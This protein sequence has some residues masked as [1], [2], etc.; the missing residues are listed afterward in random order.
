[1]GLNSDKRLKKLMKKEW[2]KITNQ[3]SGNPEILVYGVLSP[4]PDED[5]V[6]Y[7]DFQAAFRQLE[8][9][10]S[11]CTIRFN[12]LGG[13]I[14]EGFPIYDMI[15]N[16]AMRSLGIVEGCA[17]SMASVL[18]LACDEIQINQ[19]AYF[20]VHRA[21]GGVYGDVDSIRGYADQIDELETRI[22]GIY[23][24]RTGLPEATIESWMKSGVDKWINAEDCVK[25]KL[26][27]SIVQSAKTVQIPIQNL[28]GKKP[29]QVYKIFQNQLTIKNSMDKLKA[30]LIVLLAHMGVTLSASDSEEKFVDEVT[31][32]F[33]TKDDAITLKMKENAEAIV[34]AFGSGL[35]DEEKPS[36]ITLGTSNPTML[37]TMLGK[38]GPAAPAATSTTTVLNLNAQLKKTEN[39]NGGDEREKWTYLD[40]SKNDPTALA[41]METND[42][43]KFQKLISGVTANAQAKGWVK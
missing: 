26:A 21:Q 10:Y 32:A 25:F 27:D 30:T 13:S 35:K 43:E 6:S 41:K 16:S 37:I 11:N 4:F 29:D 12:C 38:L 7:Q 28:A 39:E 20:M 19:N 33:K 31:K 42:P 22:K 2:Y 14:L 9:L 23:V 17:A 36:F 18:V 24:Q 34:A 15:K 1:M 3:L 40:W 8:G 5:T